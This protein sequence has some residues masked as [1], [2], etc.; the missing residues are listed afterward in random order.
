M[1]EVRC[2]ES[3][4]IDQCLLFVCCTSIESDVVDILTT[5]SMHHNVP[6]C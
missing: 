2:K 1:Q 3:C 6:V 4:R 5:I